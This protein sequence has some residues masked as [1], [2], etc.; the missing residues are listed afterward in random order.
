MIT[1][2]LKTEYLFY[3]FYTLFL[4]IATM[5]PKPAYTKIMQEYWN[6]PQSTRQ[7]WRQSR[8]FQKIPQIA[9]KMRVC[10]S[11]Q[12]PRLC[13]LALAHSTMTRRSTDLRCS[14]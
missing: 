3:V 8:F 2:D 9:D 7:S 12:S 14:I 4:H 6:A 5:M 10:D 13:N 1:W 11:S